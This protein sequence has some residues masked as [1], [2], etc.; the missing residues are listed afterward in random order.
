MT[1]MLYPVFHLLACAPSINKTWDWNNGNPNAEPEINIVQDT[2]TNL[3]SVEMQIDATSY[4][5]WIYIDLETAELMDIPDAT[6]SEDWD[7]GAMR[8]WL[9]LNS[10]I[11]GPSTVAAIL[12]EE[13]AY[14]DII[15]PPDGEYVVDQ[16]DGDD[17]NENP[18]YVLHEWFDY[19]VNTHILTAK[20]WVYVI[21]N[22]N[23][24]YF[25]FQIE[26][27]YDNAGTSGFVTV[28]WGELE[29]LEN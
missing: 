7:I 10:G 15:T 12:E 23:D 17:E 16:V 27:Y 20:D 3:I 13:T 24:V 28:R 22:R 26:N 14:E 19:D 29:S 25:K 8:C 11:H 5:D 21:R 1:L 18:D 6:S 4:D 2:A 9:K